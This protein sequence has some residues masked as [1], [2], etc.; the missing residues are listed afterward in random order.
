MSN[1]K[2]NR[3]N[4]DR[5]NALENNFTR[6]ERGNNIQCLNPI[7][8]LMIRSADKKGKAYTNIL[9]FGITSLSSGAGVARVRS[10]RW[11]ILYLFD[12]FGVN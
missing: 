2:E 6:R 11:V 1:S 12:L 7:G 10:Y 5:I 3:V 8:Q 9:T 4:E